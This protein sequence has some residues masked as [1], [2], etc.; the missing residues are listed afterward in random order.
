[1][2]GAGGSDL[3]VRGG[4]LSW[5]P[6]CSEYRWGGDGSRTLFGYVFGLGRMRLRH[7]KYQEYESKAGRSK[8]QGL[9]PTQPW[10]ISHFLK[11]CANARKKRRSEEHTSE[12]QSPYV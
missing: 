5:I 12:L 8:N 10:R 3:S 4:N 7:Q 6:V 2:K 11:T 9:H 1:M